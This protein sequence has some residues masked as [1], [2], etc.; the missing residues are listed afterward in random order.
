VTERPLWSFVIFGFNEADS[1]LAVSSAVS[2]T[3]DRIAAGRY[4]ILLIDDG[5]TDGG[6][7][8]VHRLAQLLPG[9]RAVLHTR[10][11][12]IGG[13]LRTGYGKSRG[14][15]VVAVPA[16]GQFD[17]RELEAIGP[18]EEGAFV[19]FYRERTDGY[20][21]HRRFLT[22]ANYFLNRAALGMKLRDVNWVKIY[23]G[24]ALRALDLWSRSSLVESEICAK[25]LVSGF[26]AVEVPSRYHPRRHGRHQGA[27]LRTVLRAVAGIGK[28]VL[29][30]ALF[31]ARP[32]LGLR[33]SES[34]G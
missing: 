18:P 3:A 20:G 10:N 13:A 26:R 34:I 29:A 21:L 30:V 8:I 24:E 11:L 17:V 32:I 14:K 5:S 28:L 12:G 4:E 25:L 2:E 22:A 6:A 15:F 33:P 23:P 7:R 1:W 31:R 16:D 27:S 9:A 19:S